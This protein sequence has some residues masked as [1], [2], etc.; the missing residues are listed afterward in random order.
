MQDYENLIKA[1]VSNDVAG[2]A[3]PQGLRNILIMQGNHQSWDYFIRLRSC[4]RNTV[5]TQ[6]VTM[7]IEDALRNSFDGEDLFA[8]TGPDCVYGACRE[9]KMSCGNPL[10]KVDINSLMRQ[11][12][13][14]LFKE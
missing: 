11:K 2:Y 4:N 8:Y 9:G 1:G 6:Y 14:L 3:A 13:P 5:E 10:P 7:L 12:W